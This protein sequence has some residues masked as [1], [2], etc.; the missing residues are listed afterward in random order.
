MQFTLLQCRPQSQLAEGKEVN[1]PGHLPEKDVLL[2]TRFMVPQGV[3]DNIDTVVFVPPAAYFNLQMAE[4]FELSRVIGKLNGAL[5]GSKF[6]LVG[7]GR[8]GSTN[9]DL[10]IPI[11]YSDIF[12][13]CALVELSGKSVGPAPEPSLGTHF[14]QDLL[15]AQIYPL[16]VMLDDPQSVF[17]PSFFYH[18]PSSLDELIPS[19]EAA[20]ERVRVIRISNYRKDH[21]LRLVMDEEHSM[22]V[23]YLTPKLP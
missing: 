19:D 18:A 12:N 14:F 9:A 10:G 1:I 23:A 20:K 2:Q 7:P 5:K 6:I 22:A 21:V 4:R 16:A 3:I 17:L 11:G 8:W 15:E 13:S